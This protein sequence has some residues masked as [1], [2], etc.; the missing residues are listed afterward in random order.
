MA[1]RHESKLI[2]RHQGR[3]SLLAGGQRVRQLRYDLEDYQDYI[4][5]ES[6]SGTSRIPGLKSCQG[7]ITLLDGDAFPLL[8]QD[9]LAI[10]AED[11]RRRRIVPYGQF[12][13]LGRSPIRVKANGPWIAPAA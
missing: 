10:E 11:G 4:I 6:M 7:S 2:E 9:D 5:S 12:D 8:N 3:G 13:G 1:D